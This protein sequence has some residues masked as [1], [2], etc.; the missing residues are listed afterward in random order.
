MKYRIFFLT[1]LVIML[2]S[3]AVTAADAATVT[4]DCNSSGCTMTGAWT[5]GNQGG[6]KNETVM[7]S[8]SGSVTWVDRT[9]SGPARVYL[10]VAIDEAD[11]T[12]KADVKL[13]TEYLEKSSTISFS[14]GNAGWR[15]M[16]YVYVTGGGVYVTISNLAGGK[17]Y[18]SAVRIE[19][20]EDKY[21]DVQAFMT[22]NENHIVIAKYAQIGFFNG[23]RVNM[24]S[25]PQIIDG[26]YYVSKEAMLRYFGAYVQEDGTSLSFT[27]GGK[28][29]A[30]TVG[31]SGFIVDG[32]A[33]SGTLAIS[34]KNKNYV[35]IGEVAKNIGKYIYIS[36]KGL[37]VIT[38]TAFEFDAKTDKSKIMNIIK[39]L[40]YEEL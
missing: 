23:Q 3:A 37:A 34:V 15:D 39:A 20:L 28:A 9:Q 40:R 38:D 18:A 36:D 26:E 17:I 13:R 10:W 7:Q 6:F 35:N 14:E 1:A 4:M 33:V 16:G 22:S 27:A 24:K 31:E 29:F 30:C 8:A 12:E 25:Y 32:N 21:N 11:G 5:A 19:Y 2:F